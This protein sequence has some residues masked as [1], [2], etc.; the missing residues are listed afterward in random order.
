MAKSQRA[1]ILKVCKHFLWKHLDTFCLKLILISSFSMFTKNELRFVCSQII[2]ICSYF[3]LPFIITL[4]LPGNEK[5]ERKN[6]MSHVS[7]YCFFIPHATC[8]TLLA[9]LEFS[10]VKISPLPVEGCG[11]KPQ[12]EGTSIQV[13]PLSAGSCSGCQP[14]ACLTYTQ[15]H[16]PSSAPVSACIFLSSSLDFVIMDQL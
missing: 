3:L 9:V 10:I 11:V 2:H 7:D 13:H 12:E 6:N 14:A 16:L 8:A 15:K 4:I 5:K 1:F